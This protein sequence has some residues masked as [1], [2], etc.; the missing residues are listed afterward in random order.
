MSI[1]SDS[2]GCESNVLLPGKDTVT[3]K[4]SGWEGESG[5]FAHQNIE[6]KLI[7]AANTLVPLHSVFG[8]YNVV[9][10]QIYS[11]T[12][13]THRSPCP[14]PDHRDVQPS[15]GYNSTDDRFNCF[16]CHRSGRSVEFIAFMDNKSRIAAAKLLIGDSISLEEISNLNIE[17]FDYKRLD[18]LLFDYTDILRAFKKTN[19]YTHKAVEYASAVT[20]NLDVYLR[21]HVPFNSIVLDDLDVRI[22]KLIEQLEAYEELV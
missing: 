12:G 5:A 7:Q 19:K 22:S 2:S 15:F 6:Y 1:L 9:L 14:F 13:W 21:K 16:G 11:S 20:W 4:A 3:G 8:Q 18:R 10:E 17:R